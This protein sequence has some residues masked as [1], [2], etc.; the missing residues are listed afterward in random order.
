M[1]RATSLFIIGLVCLTMGVA[2]AAGTG[3]SGN[4]KSGGS[5]KGSL[6]VAKAD[7]ETILALAAACIKRC[8]PK[9]KD[10]N[11]DT[12]DEV[13]SVLAKSKDDPKK[14]RDVVNDLVNQF[15]MALASAKSF[16]T[17]TTGAGY[18]VQYSPGSQRTANL[19]GSILSVDDRYPENTTSAILVFEYAV[20][21][22]PETRLVRLNL[23]NAYLDA[24]KLDKAK[25]IIDKL[26]FED[27]EDRSAWRTMAT[28][29]YKKKDMGNFRNALLRAA[30][31]KGYVKKKT[32]KKNKKVA[33][34]EVKPEDS[35]EQI[36]AKLPGLSE[37][38]PMTTADVIEDDFIDQALKIRDKYSKLIDTEKLIMPK[39]PQVNTNSPKEFQRNSPIIEMWVNVMCSKM[40]KWAK[41]QALEKYGITGNESKAVMQ[42]KAQA[43]ANKEMAKAMQQAKDTLEYMKNI[44]GMEGK[45]AEIEKALRKLQ[46][47]AKNTKTTGPG[48]TKKPLGIHLEDNPVDMN[49]IP[50]FDSGSEF[51]E[52]NYSNYMK[53]KYAYE[54]WFFKY[55]KEFQAKVADIYRVYGKKVVEED[56]Q[57]KDIWERLQ[58]EHQDDLEQNERGAHSDKDFPCR[59]ETLRY[60]KALN[61]VSDNY[62]KQWVNIYMPQYA[63]KMKPTLDAYWKTCGLY[64]KNMNDAEVM[65]REYEHC[66]STYMFY[67]MQACSMI[68]G[69]GAFKYYGETDEEE[70]QLEADI[71]AAKEEA[72]KKKPE[73]EK[74]FKEPDFDWTKWIED[75]LVLEI[76][77]EALTFKI[78]AKTIEFEAFVPGLAAGIKIDVVDEKVETYTAVAAKLDVGVNIFGIEAKLEDKVEF[79][80]KTAQWDFAN[81]KYTE[82]YGSKAEAKAAFGILQGTA[83][84]ELEYDS[85]IRAKADYNLGVGVEKE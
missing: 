52:M 72:E 39:L 67:G 63:Q 45:R 44:P 3:K 85:E 19:F 51:A 57:H 12:I 53:V 50:G 64:I 81:G 7:K 6:K 71:A 76:A 25:P 10:K 35:T 4:G 60:H 18:L 26:I 29:Y 83:S 17:I 82:T 23:A 78:T 15:T 9:L 54:M 30:K 55:L 84:V 5:G 49:K 16:D 27:Q 66:R 21:I 1:K 46:N 2:T 42:T 40:A 43:G 31:F 73:F 59:K 14:L 62:Y 33:D 24:G 47:T 36:E 61:T 8:E 75:H 80:K 48:N 79:A 65:K 74:E 68:S 38:T 20:S 41:Q 58:K 34:Q 32:D 77:V 70:R 22:K 37:E 69:G 13:K 11:K 56:D 28:Y